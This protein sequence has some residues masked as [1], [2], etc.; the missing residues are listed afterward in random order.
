LNP[1]SKNG[2]QTPC[3]K[4]YLAFIILARRITIESQPK[5]LNKDKKPIF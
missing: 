2:R 1:P 5:K 4:Y 3:S